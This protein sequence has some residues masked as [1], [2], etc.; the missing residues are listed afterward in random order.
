MKLQSA[1]RKEVKRIAVGTCVF[2]LILI[3]GLFLLSQFGIGTFSLGRILL[4]VAGGTAV[5]IL[6]FIVMCLTVQ[7]AVEI[8]DQKQMKAF[9]QGSYNGRLLLQAGWVI[10]ALLVPQI[11]AL[12]G[13]APLLFPNL[14]IFYLQAKGKLVTPSDRKNPPPQDDEEPEDHLGSFEV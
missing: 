10:V 9:F 1:S 2:D 13:A 11:H 8:S 12:A 4:G 5:A 7:K 3:A 6:N 14:T